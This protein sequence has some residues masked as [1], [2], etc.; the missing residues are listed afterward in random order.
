MRYFV[1]FIATVFFYSCVHD[2]KSTS[3]ID[4]LWEVKKVK[5]GDQEMTPVARWMRFN[6]DSTQT[7][8]NGWLQHSIGSWSLNDKNQL[9]VHNSNGLA[10]NYEPFSIV[11][12][13][14]NMIWSR[15]EEGQNV[16]VFL[17]RIVKIPASDGNK[18]MGLWKLE[19]IKPT[20]DEIQPKLKTIY[21]S[22]DN[23][24][25][26]QFVSGKKEYG[27]YKIH[28]HKPELQM[29]NYG[30][31][32]EFEFY[33]FTMDGNKLILKSTDNKKEFNFS[34]IHQFLQ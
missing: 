31:K 11:L 17:K 5:I 8:G 7:S 24:F 12:K 3:K 19:N 23:R 27:I 21:I 32:P 2:E 16:Q 9:T 6:A 10:D 29:V 25:I 13:E 28:G 14:D 34:R 22:W 15:E 33:N 4:G 18:L 20:K 30:E 1:L 26:K